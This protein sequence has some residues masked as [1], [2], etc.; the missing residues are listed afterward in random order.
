MEELR[1]VCFI[2]LA[3]RQRSVRLWAACAIIPVADADPGG[4]DQ[5][6]RPGAKHV[7]LAIEPVSVIEAS[8]VRFGVSVEG[9][10]V[11]PVSTRHR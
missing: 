2:V 3:D 6:S 1:R 11:V 10:S 7:R 9:D 8:K 4:I 5:R